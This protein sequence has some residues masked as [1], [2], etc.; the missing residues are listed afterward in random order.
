MLGRSL[1]RNALANLHFRRQQVIAGFI[2][3]FY[4]AAA[5]LVIEIDGDSHLGRKVYDSQRD[6]VFDELGMRTLRLKGESVAHNLPEV[7]RLIE[8]EA[9]RSV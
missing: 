2:A 8:H 7:L 1:R 5:R 4:C 9:A 3:D 6:N